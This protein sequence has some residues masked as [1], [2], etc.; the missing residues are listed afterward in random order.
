M[1]WNMSRSGSAAWRMEWKKK[2]RETRRVFPQGLTPHDCK[3][4]VIVKLRKSCYSTFLTCSAAFQGLIKVPRRYNRLITESIFRV[5][6]FSLNNAHLVLTFGY[7]RQGR[8][9]GP[10]VVEVFLYIVFQKEE[11]KG[12]EIF[13]KLSRRFS[14]KAL[15]EERFKRREVNDQNMKCLGKG[16][17]WEW[18]QRHG[19]V[20][21]KD[22][23]SSSLALQDPSVCLSPPPDQT[24]QWKRETATW[25]QDDYYIQFPLPFVADHICNQFLI[26]W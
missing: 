21:L 6:C 14:A 5:F 25:K 19:E 17:G 4:V 9:W 15:E 8:R 13:N 7:G 16:S 23:L 20:R 11:R 22:Y 10:K 12:G 24:S 3:A 2:E 1:L 26:V 18:S